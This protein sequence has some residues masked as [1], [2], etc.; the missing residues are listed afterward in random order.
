MI[1]PLLP[2]AEFLTPP[3]MFALCT[4]L[5]SFLWPRLTLTSRLLADM[6]QARL[7]KAP[8]DFHFLFLAPLH[9]LRDLIQSVLWEDTIY[10]AELSHPSHFRQGHPGLVESQPAPDTCAGPAEIELPRHPTLAADAW[11][12]AAQASQAQPSPAHISRTLQ[13]LEPNAHLS[14]YA[15]DNR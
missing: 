6:T 4:L 9:L 15:I 11:V 10:A 7:L 3:Y 13:I 14:L 2:T 12:S 5:V 1:P 8:A